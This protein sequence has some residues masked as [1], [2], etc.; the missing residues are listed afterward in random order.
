M[1]AAFI[2]RTI[3]SGVDYEIFDATRSMLTARMT[4]MITSHDICGLVEAISQE[5]PSVL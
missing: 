4:N 1:R 2:C 5:T 3:I